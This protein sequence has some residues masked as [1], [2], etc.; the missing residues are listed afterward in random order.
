[1]SHHRKEN[2][3]SAN[4]WR[5]LDKW[6]WITYVYV[7]F[8]LL[9]VI[10]S[11]GI[12]IQDYRV[13]IS[14]II[15]TIALGWLK[16]CPINWYDGFK[17]IKILVIM[18]IIMS[19]SFNWFYNMEFRSSLIAQDFPD[20]IEHF[21]QLDILKNGFFIA[22]NYQ[23]NRYIT[24]LLIIKTEYL[25]TKVMGGQWLWLVL[26]AKPESGIL[27]ISGFGVTGH[28]MMQEK[29]GHLMM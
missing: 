27:M 16:P 4:I 6:T 22:Q 29:T 18:W 13:N 5:S 19:M 15:V 9:M 28:L 10:T 26:K 3:P 23:G 12:L 17:S 2:V 25:T 21:D 8:S 7:T 11:F 1:M 24:H 14:E 20:D